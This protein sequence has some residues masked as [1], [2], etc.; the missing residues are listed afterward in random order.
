MANHYYTKN[1]DSISQQKHWTYRLKGNT[2]SFTSDN[3]VFSKTKV[4][5]GT[6]VMLK[7]F[8][9][10]NQNKKNKKYF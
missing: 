2:L 7:V 5:F 10:E 1:P 4:D 8:L 6:D 9:R 3:G